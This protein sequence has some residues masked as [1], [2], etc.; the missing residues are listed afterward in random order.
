MNWKWPKTEEN[1]LN[2]WYVVLWRLIFYLPAIA[3]AIILYILLWVG[4]GK[5]KARELA[6]AFK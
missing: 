3:T 4:F 5:E 6:R 1:D 2:A